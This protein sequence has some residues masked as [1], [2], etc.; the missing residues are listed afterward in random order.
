MVVLHVGA[1]VLQLWQPAQ[2][3]SIVHILFNL[4]GVQTRLRVCASCLCMCLGCP[5]WPGC[6]SCKSDQYMSSTPLSRANTRISTP[7]YN[8]HARGCTRGAPMAARTAGLHVW[9]RSS[10][11]AHARGTAWYRLGASKVP[12]KLYVEHVYRGFG[13]G[14]SRDPAQLGPENGTGIRPRVRG[15]W[16]WHGGTRLDMAA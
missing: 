16:V 6:N 7:Q 11:T 4:P 2:H 9:S 5:C 10:H 3:F 15:V 1:E 14:T 8:V 13:L 12:L